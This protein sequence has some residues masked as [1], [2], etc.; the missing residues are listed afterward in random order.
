MSEEDSDSL[1][2]VE[3]D[4]TNGDTVPLEVISNG[5]RVYVDPAESIGSSKSIDAKRAQDILRNSA[6]DDSERSARSKTSLERSRLEELRKKQ[7]EENQSLSS[8]MLGT[9]DVPSVDSATANSRLWKFRMKCG[10]LVENPY[11]QVF[12]IILI[13]LNTIVLG[14]GTADFVTENPDVENIFHQIDNCFL[15]IFTIEL[16]LQLIYRGPALFHDP[17]LV[18]DFVFVALSWSVE[19]LQIARSVRVFRAFRLVTRIESL[20]TLVLAIG[21]VMPNLTAIG[22][23]LLLVFY[24]FAILFTNL[25]R[26]IK[27]EQNYF[28]DLPHSLFT[29]LELT[30]LEWAGIARGVM[31][32]YSWAWAPFVAFVVMTG[33]I[34]FNLFIAVICDALKVIDAQERAE[35]EARELAILQLE[36]D[37]FEASADERIAAL[38][39]EL[40]A[41]KEREIVISDKVAELVG[42]WELQKREIQKRQKQRQRKLRERNHLSRISSGRVDTSLLSTPEKT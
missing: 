7:M 4:F 39:E 10:A 22:F 28:E 16:G 13:L 40:A 6:F 30:T 36:S 32:V 11:V 38:A 35:E 29:C 18:F 15:Y 5:E 33:F 20:R 3:I 34:F 24:I 23:L 2:S 12:I 17:W 19:W 9:W 41:M 27:L 26:D 8:A 25:F 14:V 31:E 1:G 42:E 37:F 21:H